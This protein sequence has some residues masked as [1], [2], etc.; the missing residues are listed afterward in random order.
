MTLDELFE[1]YLENHSKPNKKSWRVDEYRYHRYVAKPFGKRKLSEISRSEIAALHR[2]ISRQINPKHRGVGSPYKIT[3]ANRILILV[4]VIYQWGIKTEQCEENPA[5]GIARF[6]VK[7][8]DRFLQPE[9]L[10]R[11]FNAIQKEENKNVHDYVLLSL[12]TGARRG[13]VLAM[14]WEEISF[15]NKLWRIPTTKNGDPLVIPLM[16]EALHILNTRKGN[17][18]DFVF[19]G[20]VNLQRKPGQ[21]VKADC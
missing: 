14:R 4:S 3:M 2:K 5:R 11:F 13:N 9:E 8:R 1:D 21:R 6:P 10:V 7:S 19:P 12:Y 15:E 16:A 17:G 20:R 18:S